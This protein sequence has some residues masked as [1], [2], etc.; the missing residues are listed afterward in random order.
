MM[1]DRRRT[2]MTSGPVPAGMRTLVLPML[3]LATLASVAPTASASGDCTDKELGAGAYE[4][5]LHR[6]DCLRASYSHPTAR[7]S[8]GVDVG[9]YAGTVLCDG[10]VTVL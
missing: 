9:V 1:A 8:E 5:H 3:L 2:L 7:C 4:V 10:R 6:G